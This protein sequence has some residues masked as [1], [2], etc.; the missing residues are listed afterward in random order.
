MAETDFQ[1][2]TIKDDFYRDSFGKVILIIVGICFAIAL[3]VATS[4]YFYITKPAPVVFPLGDEWRVQP[5]VA[6]NQRYLSDADL[7]QWV[8]DVFQKAFLFD[9]Y[10]YND[11]LKDVTPYFTPDG[12]SVFLN[13]LN[14]Y[15]NYNKVQAAK[16]FV[17]SV[18]T[19]A[20]TIINQGLLSGRYGW[21]VRIPLNITY[22]GYNPPMM[23]SLTLQV[24]V[25]RVPTVSNLSGVGIDNVIVERTTATLG[26]GNG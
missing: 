5:D 9:F 19:G 21:W 16:L 24:L 4:V 26:A 3:L 11:Q 12:W 13:Q 10:H 17:N 20:P 2:I 6:V 7:L 1:V 18:P 23:Q 22:S 25:V 15:A 8:S 14:I